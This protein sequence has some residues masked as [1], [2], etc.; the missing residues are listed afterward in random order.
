MSYTTLLID[1]CTTQRYSAGA[2]DAYGNS[3]RTWTDFLSSQACRLQSITTRIGGRELTVN[4]E[5][6]VAEYKLFLQDIDI[7]EQDR[8]VIGTV[9]YQ[10]LLVSRLQDGIDSHHRECLLKVV[11]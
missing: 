8:V 9:T 2:A 11:R 7:T 5:V 10:V 4:A 3:A 1:T 6:V